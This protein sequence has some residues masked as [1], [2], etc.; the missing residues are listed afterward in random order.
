MEQKPLRSSP[1]KIAQKPSMV[2]YYIGPRGIIFYLLAVLVLFFGVI[3]Y[4]EY[5]RLV[6]PYMRYYI[7]CLPAGIIAGILLFFGF[8]SRVT[9]L[10]RIHV[11]PN[12]PRDQKSNG[13]DAT[14]GQSQT[15][16]GGEK[17]M[18][19]TQGS[20]HGS[21]LRKYKPTEISKD[22]LIAKKRNLQQFLNNLDEQHRDRLITSNVYLSLKTKYHH[23]L[24]GVNGLLKSKTQR[25]VKRVKK[26]KDEDNKTP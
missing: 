2:R 25:P 21:G 9:T 14:S 1:M 16:M 12:A 11:P 23:E 4:V 3:G 20:S 15:E 17:W 8:A 19:G 7:C 13:D 5:D 10:R 18:D 22:D 6:V 24:S 26:Q